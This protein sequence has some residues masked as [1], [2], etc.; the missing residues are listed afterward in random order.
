MPGLMSSQRVKRESILWF[1]AESEGLTR[2]VLER[3]FSV[4]ELMRRTLFQQAE[5]RGEHDGCSTEESGGTTVILSNDGL[6]VVDR[7]RG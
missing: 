6:I 3:L 2:E 7:F 4:E 1:V 5:G